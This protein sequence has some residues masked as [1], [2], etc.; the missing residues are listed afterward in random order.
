MKIQVYVDAN[1]LAVRSGRMLS[2]GFS[3][4]RNALLPLLGAI[5]RLRGHAVARGP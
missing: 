2:I 3:V 1:W 5:D 4:L